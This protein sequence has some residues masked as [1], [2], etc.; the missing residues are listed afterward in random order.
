RALLDSVTAHLAAIPEQGL[1]Y[2]LL[3]YVARAAELRT[4]AEPQVEFNYLGR[5]TGTAGANPDD[6]IARF[7]E[8]GWV[9]VADLGK[10]DADMDP[11]MP[12]NG[13]IDINAIV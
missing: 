8:L 12:A 4:G 6:P 1:D 11:D 9:P 2:G 10:L 3:R 7:A 5:V 13:T